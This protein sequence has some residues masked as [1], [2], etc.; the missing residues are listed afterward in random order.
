M[1]LPTIAHKNGV[2][3]QLITPCQIKHKHRFSPNTSRY[4]EG[5]VTRTKISGGRGRGKS[6]RWPPRRHHHEVEGMGGRR[7]RTRRRCSRRR[8]GP[9]CEICSTS[10]SSCGRGPRCPPSPPSTTPSW[11]VASGAAPPT[12]GPAPKAKRG[13]TTNRSSPSR[14]RWKRIAAARA[15]LWGWRIWDSPQGRRGVE[16]GHRRAAARRPAQIAARLGNCRMLRNETRCGVGIEAAKRRYVGIYD[17][18]DSSP[19]LS[20]TSTSKKMGRKC[21]CLVKGNYYI[22]QTTDNR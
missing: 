21:F 8:R 18:V 19:D 2:F 3:T 9:P 14:I 22:W 16:L 4:G 13:R 11:P 6:S 1:S 12:R 5:P 20:F 17:R 7:R 15:L 10:W